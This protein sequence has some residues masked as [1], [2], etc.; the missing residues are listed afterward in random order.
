MSIKDGALASGI[1]STAALGVDLL[2]NGGEVILMGISIL[3]DQSTLIYLLLS[4]LR[5]AAPNVAWLPG[6]EL[7]MAFTAVSLL[8]AVFAL[9]RLSRN[10]SNRFKSKS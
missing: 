2:L 6:A 7:N 4:R 8:L 1:G 9:Y 10:I 3:M 5:S